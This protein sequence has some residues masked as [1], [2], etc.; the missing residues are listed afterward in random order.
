MSTSND[1]SRRLKIRL[2]RQNLF[3]TK[4]EQ[5]FKMHW[6]FLNSLLADQ[7]KEIHDARDCW[8]LEE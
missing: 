7:N 5:P 6:A 4:I 3:K 8:D 2:T 1:L